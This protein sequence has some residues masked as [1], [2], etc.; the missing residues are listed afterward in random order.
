M[1]IF[2][3][4]GVAESDGVV[5]PSLPA[6]QYDCRVTKVEERMTSPQAEKYPQHPYLNFS[7]IVKEGQEGEGQKL[8][9]MVMS[10][11]GMDGEDKRKS[12][13]KMKHLLDACQM[14]VPEDGNIESQDFVS[15]EL[16]L[17]VIQSNRGGQAGNEVTDFLPIT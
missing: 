3:F 6:G 9:F 12:I 8:F 16:R 2:K 15:Q 17:V 7:A 4:D 1:S 13:A 11:E 14:D 5:F 10:P